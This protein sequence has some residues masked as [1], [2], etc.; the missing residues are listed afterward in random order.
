MDDVLVGVLAI[1]VGAL[2]CFRGYL[3][4]RLIIPIWGAFAGFLLGA[5]L[6]ANTGSDG[7]L[8]STLG[9]IGFVLGI[10]VQFRSTD[11]I[12]GIM[13]EAWAESGRSPATA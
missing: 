7:F 13:R 1:A 4:M 11:R 2:F 10:V 12:R 3:A 8:R 9:W 6:I 5:G